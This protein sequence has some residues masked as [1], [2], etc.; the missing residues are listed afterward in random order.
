VLLRA[1]PPAELA[2]LGAAVLADSDP[3]RRWIATMIN[4][5][6]KANPKTKLP[7]RPK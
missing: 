7:C 1:M 3:A 2:L 4:T 6:T 5:P